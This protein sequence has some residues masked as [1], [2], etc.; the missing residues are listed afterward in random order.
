[1]SNL[2]SSSLGST[3]KQSATKFAERQVAGAKVSNITLCVCLSVCARGIRER[4][5]SDAPRVW[6]SDVK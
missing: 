4:T 1:M 2:S 5:L 6:A 3:R